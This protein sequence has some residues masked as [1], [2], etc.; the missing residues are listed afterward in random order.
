MRSAS[1]GG[2]KRLR[3]RGRRSGKLYLI[4]LV[5]LAGMLTA[6]EVRCR[7]LRIAG[8]EIEP[9]AVPFVCE[10]V[11]SGVPARAEKFWPLLWMSKR[12]YETAIEKAHPVKARL[13]LKNWGRYKLDVEFLQPLFVLYWENKYW[14][15]SSDG[16]MWLTVRPEN[17]MADLSAA[18]R[19]PVLVWGRDRT[20]PFDIANA[21]GG[22]YRSSL[23]M[24]LI[25]AWYDSIE[26]LG[27]TEKTKALY[28]ERREGQEAVRL[29]AID[30]KG[31]RGAEILFPD[32]SEHWREAGMA[33]KSIYPDITKISTDIFID[34][35][36]KG[37]II[38]SNKVK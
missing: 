7:T 10:S 5:I 33:M 6:A 36:Y 28:T 26:F 25:L 34:M 20:S 23:P 29:I 22:A 35:T 1:S 37:K 19:L 8:I 9:M 31:G 16:K 11:W 15:V 2:S 14:Y 18:R 4:L 30:S 27:W 17:V 3:K 24:A 21:D 32:S 38:V 12:S 13:L